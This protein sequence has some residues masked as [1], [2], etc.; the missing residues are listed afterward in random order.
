MPTNPSPS[1]DGDVSASHPFMKALS[2]D[3]LEKDEQEDDSGFVPCIM[4]WE[5]DMCD[6]VCGLGHGG[7]MFY[8]HALLTNKD[9]CVTH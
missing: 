2:D 9:M 1:A 8:I 7:V 6:S 5:H 4:R 3:P